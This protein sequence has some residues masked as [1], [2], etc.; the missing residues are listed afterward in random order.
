MKSK[1]LLTFLFFTLLTILFFT[2]LA[3]RNTPIAVYIPQPFETPVTPIWD[4][5]Q[6]S[7]D[8]KPSYMWRSPGTYIY[9]ISRDGGSNQ[10]FV[11]EQKLMTEAANESQS[12]DTPQRATWPWDFVNTLPEPQ[13]SVIALG[14]DSRPGGYLLVSVEDVKKKTSWG[15]VPA[16]KVSITERYDAF[17]G[18]F[19]IVEGSQKTSTWY[20]CG[21]GLVHSTS[22]HRGTKNRKSFDSQS[23]S[24]LVSFTPLSTNESHVRYILVDIQLNHRAY[25]YYRANTTDEETAEALRRWNAGIRVVNIEEFERKKINEQWQIVYAGTENSING[26]DGILNCD[27]QQ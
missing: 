22:S 12:P 8:E 13:G 19:D 23:E 21:Y 16:I 6:V 17:T 27:S 15:T 26:M 9:K 11:K 2:I 4:S 10:Y 3:A 14:E 25:Y 20:V 1:S 24:V 5:M 7:C 18:R